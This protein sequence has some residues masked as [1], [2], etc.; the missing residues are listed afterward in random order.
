MDRWVLTEHP[1]SENHR[2]FD[3][4]ALPSARSLPAEA[5]GEWLI[6]LLQMLGVWRPLGRLWRQ[7]LGG[8]GN[9]TGCV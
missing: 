7:R 3:S 6:V 9:A 1:N 5:R 2:H 4:Q 8:Y